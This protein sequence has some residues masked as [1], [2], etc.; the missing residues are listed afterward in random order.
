MPHFPIFWYGHTY[1]VHQFKDIGYIP[2]L[3]RVV[4]IACQRSTVTAGLI[5]CPLARMYPP[6]GAHSCINRLVYVS[7]SGIVPVASMTG[8]TLPTSVSRSPY[9]SLILKMLYSEFAV[10]GSIGLSASI[11]QSST[12]SSRISDISPS[13]CNNIL[14]SRS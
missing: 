2:H 10:I 3:S 6:P 8:D 13:E 14:Q 12:R 1:L 11:L 5:L 7:I 9:F 4:S